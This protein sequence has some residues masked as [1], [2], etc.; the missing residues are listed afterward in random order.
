MLRQ[1]SADDAPAITACVLR[2][3]ATYASRIPYPPKPVLADYAA[4]VR[5]KPTWLLEQEGQCVGVLVLVPEADHLL[6]ENVAVD[7]AY[8]GRGLGRQLL[9]FAEAEARRLGLPEVRL[10]TNA[11]MTE[12]Q[13]IYRARGYAETERRAFDGRE[14]VFMRKRLL[15][16]AAGHPDRRGPATAG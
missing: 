15:P 1:A 13:T 9:D 7:P 14:V 5:D 12:N 2:A 11:L 3:Y 4:V 10:Y 6:L 16:G 8:Q